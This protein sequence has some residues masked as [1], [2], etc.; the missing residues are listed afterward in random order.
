MYPSLAWMLPCAAVALTLLYTSF[1]KRRWV[2]ITAFALLAMPFL[3]ALSSLLIYD[4]ID[5]RSDTLL[6]LWP[7]LL[8]A[9]T[10]LA[11][12]NLLRSGRNLDLH[13]LLPF[14]ILVAINGTLMSQQLWGST[15][16]IWPL[17]V[18][19]LAETIAS[20]S[21]RTTASRWFA[22]AFVSLISLTFLVCGGFYMASEDRLSY[23][24]FPDGPTLHSAFPQLA[25][26]STPGEY[27]PEF[28]ELLRYVQ[29]NI[30]FNDGLILLP[31]EDP[32]YF[33]TGRVPRFPV[34]LFDKA[35]DPYSPADIAAL[36]RDRNIR[37]FILKRDLQINEDPTPN[38]DATIQAL[39]QE[40]TLAAH[41]RGYDVYRR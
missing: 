12:V 8:L 4:D 3:F 37:W 30:P 41:L 35:T 2:Q 6:E 26:M 27:L 34:L 28:D 24:Q 23:A 10:A 22:P 15:Y 38:R 21:A 1:G 17:L 33:A 16:A 11:L 40:F 13:T 9:A 7:L 19:L 32:F 14:V 25:G 18:L 29:V 20:F 5:E 36:V 31:G 39:M